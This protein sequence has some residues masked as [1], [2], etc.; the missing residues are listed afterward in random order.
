MHTLDSFTDIF[1]YF[2]WLWIF[3][4]NIQNGYGAR[5]VVFFEQLTKLGNNIM[6]LTSTAQVYAMSCK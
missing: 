5:I 4:F 2:T 6:P 1:S 3:F